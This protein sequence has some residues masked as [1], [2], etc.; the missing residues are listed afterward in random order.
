MQ[1]DKNNTVVGYTRFMEKQGYTGRFE[2]EK[3]K[4][5]ELNNGE[6]YRPA[7]MEIVE[8]KRFE[9]MTNP[10]DMSVVYAVKC[11]DGTKGLITASFGTYANV[12]LAEFIRKLE[13]TEV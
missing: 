7:D 4:L 8:F 13:S 3:G 9:G 10:S 11:M 12:E 1:L 5:K 6:F 2:M